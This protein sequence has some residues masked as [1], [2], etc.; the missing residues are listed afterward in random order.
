ML[1]ENQIRAW[2]QKKLEGYIWKIKGKNSYGSMKKLET[3]VS[4][5]QQIIDN[6]KRLMKGEDIKYKKGVDK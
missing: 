5:L 3:I 2:L 4:D 1:S 6:L